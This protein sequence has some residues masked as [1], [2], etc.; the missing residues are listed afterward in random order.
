MTERES[1]AEFYARLVA[2][3]W[4]RKRAQQFKLALLAIAAL[5]ASWW[6]G[7]LS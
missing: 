3:S 5:G 2:E 1:D 7:G 4:R 6:L